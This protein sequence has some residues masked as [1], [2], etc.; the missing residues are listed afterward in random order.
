INPSRQ[1]LNPSSEQ[2]QFEGITRSARGDG[3]IEH[4]L[5]A[6]AVAL[7]A[8]ISMF[9]ECREHRKGQW[10]ASEPSTGAAIADRAVDRHRHGAYRRQGPPS[11][12]C[13][14]LRLARIRIVGI[15][16]HWWWR[17]RERHRSVTPMGR[18]EVEAPREGGDLMRHGCPATAAMV[19]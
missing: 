18:R 19:R 10:C 1:I 17:S 3:P 2:V 14:L 11:S 5:L 15:G 9:K 12:G 7:A 8:C 13:V 16:G 6:I 4:R